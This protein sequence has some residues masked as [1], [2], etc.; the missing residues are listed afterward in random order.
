MPAFRQDRRPLLGGDRQTY[1]GVKIYRVRLQDT[2]LPGGNAPAHLQY[3]NGTQEVDGATVQTIQV[4]D[5]HFQVLGFKGE[6]LD[7]WH[8]SDMIVNP[9]D[10]GAPTFNRFEPVHQHGLMRLGQYKG[11]PGLPQYWA[12]GTAQSVEI[13]GGN[14]GGETDQHV[15]VLASNTFPV[16]VAP[17][18][19]LWIESN[20]MTLDHNGANFYVVAPLTFG[21]L[22]LYSG[23]GYW[24]PGSSASV[25]IW[26]GTPGAETDQ[27]LPVYAFNGF[28]IVGP[29]TFVWLDHNGYAW[30]VV[31]RVEPCCWWQMCGSGW[32]LIRGLP[33]NCASP[34]N[35]SG[36]GGP[37]LLYDG[38]V[39]VICPKC[40]GTTSTSTSVSSTSTSTSTPTGSTPSSK[41][42]GGGPEIGADCGTCTSGTTPYNLFAEM[43]AFGSGTN[44][45]CC[46]AIL[47]GNAFELT[48]LISNACVWR[49]VVAFAGDST[50]CD[51]TPLAGN[52]QIQGEF[53]TSGGDV[54]F[55][56]F[57]EAGGANLVWSS[58]PL[59][60][61]DAGP[62]DCLAILKSLTLSFNAAA[63]G[64]SLFCTD[65]TG[66]WDFD[67]IFISVV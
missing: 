45:A 25:R 61:I 37:P 8:V 55:N 38:Q 10:G 34:P 3:W 28:D 30:Y 1:D 60:A 44:A 26:G 35:F 50:P 40:F 52:F 41:P 20:G 59:F 62:V 13:W 48:Q 21:V 15:S 4:Y 32:R 14:L 6:L 33:A 36:S 56:V 64:A 12:P 18:A 65:P 57:I 66:G 5:P 11:S 16:P 22:A 27:A 51:L 31:Q 58:A 29:N 7:V 2:L 42:W 9:P 47:S 53:G 63:S 46:N 67:D 54:V 39:V 43:P 19:F 17:N 24:F 23:G 49:Y